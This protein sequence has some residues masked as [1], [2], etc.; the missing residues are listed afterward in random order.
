MTTAAPTYPAPHLAETVPTAQAPAP[1]AQ[2]PADIQRAGAFA[3]T[4]FVLGIASIVA[5]WTFVAPVIGLVFGLLALR[6]GARERTLALW[7]VWLN[8][9]MLLISAILLLVGA[10]ALMLALATG[11][12]TW[13]W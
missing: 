3:V 12:F 10:G 9:A 5:G 8:A 4:S 7:G 11:V 6:R 1:T 2:T 13:A